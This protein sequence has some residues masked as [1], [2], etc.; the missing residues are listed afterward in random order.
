MKAIELKITRIGNSRGIRLPA[1]VIHRYK[2]EDTV[3]LEQRPDELALRPKKSGKLSWKE[4][5]EQMA[6]AKE[7]LS[8]LEGVV[9]DGLE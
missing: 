9:A 6:A 5:Y 8:N 3:L 7:D 2:L 1:D 4:T